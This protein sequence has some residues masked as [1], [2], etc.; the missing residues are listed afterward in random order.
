VVRVSG[1]GIKPLAEP[2]R[3]SFGVR[4][5]PGDH[6]WKDSA[7]SVLFRDG[8]HAEGPIAPCEVQ[9][10]VY[11]AHRRTAELAE[12]VW[13]DK[14]LARGL[15]T[16]AEVLRER[17]DRNFWMENRGYYALSLDGAARRVDSVTSNIGHLLWSGIVPAER[18]R[19]VTDRYMDDEL[20]CGRGIRTMA[21]GE[22]G[23]DPDS[24]HYRSVWPHYNALL[25]CGLRRYGFWEEASRVAAALLDAASHFDH[26]L[27]EVFAGY[28]KRG[29]RAGGAAQVLHPAGVGGRDGAAPRAHD[30]RR[31]P[32]DE[33]IARQPRSVRGCQGSVA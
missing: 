24:Y 33:K 21:A 2:G 14:D 11:D 5:E 10:Y 22:G 6:G 15:R 30:A 18:A 9:G 3:I 8:S 17:F 7:N 23:Y 32:W 27:P 25:A 16:E 28:Q 4:V 31:G 19:L 20:F 26:R 1:Q 29:S 12:L 13:E